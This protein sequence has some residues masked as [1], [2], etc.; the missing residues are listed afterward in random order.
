MKKRMILAALICVMTL[1]CFSGC[2]SSAKTTD[3]SEKVELHWVFG[4]PGKLED[5]DKVWS[6]FNEQLGSYLPNTTVKF[7]CI[8]HADYAEKWRLMSAAQEECDIAWVSWA[9]DFVEE[10]SKGSY[11]DMTELIE[12]Y[13]QDMVA[14]FPDWLLELT[15][16][17]GKVYAIPNYQMMASPVGFSIDKHHV[18][19][20][21]LNLEDA[22]AVFAQDKVLHKDDYKIFE[23]YFDK[24]QASGESVKYI[25]SQFINRGLKYKIGYPVGGLETLICNAVIKRTDTDYKVYDLLTDFPD[26][27]EYYDL[28]N[29][30]YKK[31]YIRP[32]ILENPNENEGDYLLWWTSVFK[33]SAERVSLK[34]GKPMEIFTADDSLYINHKGSSTNTAIASNSKHPDRAM[35]LLNIM[36]SH[37]GADL[38]NLLTYGFEN[39]HY[40]KVSDDRVEW[41]EPGVPGASENRYGYENWAL[42]NALITYT[43]QNDPDGWNEYLHNDINMNATMSRLGGF[44]IDLKPIKMQ[45]AQYNAVMKEY[46]YLDKGTTEN[47]KA[48]LEERNAK[49]KEAGSEQ[50]VQEVQR[51]VD[52]WAEKQK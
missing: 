27:Y 13:G 17:N 45:I 16:V 19:N 30:W 24:V 34:L 15:T 20:N 21:W 6:A 33:G 29:E 43:T 50:I 10:V 44:S 37:K 41:L 38:L 48:L 51:Q 14:D 40:K 28:V 39:D 42:G 23:N 32:D 5:S 12:Q 9:L 22:A 49:L 7:T 36:N 3:S 46:E 26:T 25:S 8:P 2:G 11:L 52:E 1:G 35:Q 18:D 47:Y 31:G 4:G